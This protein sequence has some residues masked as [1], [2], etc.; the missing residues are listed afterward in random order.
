MVLSHMW[1]IAAREQR[2]TAKIYRQDSIPI[3]RWHFGQISLELNT[4]IV[5]QAVDWP[6]GA[7]LH[8]ASDALFARHV[9][10]DE[11]AKASSCINLLWSWVA[12]YFID[13]GDD[14]LGPAAQ[15]RPFSYGFQSQRL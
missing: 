13:I 4:G 5:D 3:R 11:T 14:D 8:H 15:R 12:A 9:C 1:G 10:L 2:N 7:E 6:K